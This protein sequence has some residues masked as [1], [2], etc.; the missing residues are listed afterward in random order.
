MAVQLVMNVIFSSDDIGNKSFL[1]PRNEWQSGK[2]G[3][4]AHLEHELNVLL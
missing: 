3:L 1:W 4:P 2:P